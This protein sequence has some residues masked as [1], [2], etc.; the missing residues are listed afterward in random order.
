M[1]PGRGVRGK[2]GAA[3]PAYGMTVLPPPPGPPPPGI[4]GPVARVSSVRRGR[5]VTRGD[6]QGRRALTALDDGVIIAGSGLACWWSTTVCGEGAP[7]G[8]RRRIAD[9]PHLGNAG[10]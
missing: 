9:K 2:A 5:S 4:A 10:G 8:F 1:E 3:R 6:S 7:G